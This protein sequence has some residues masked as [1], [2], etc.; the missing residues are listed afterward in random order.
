L[1]SLDNLLR[2]RKM[3]VILDRVFPMHCSRFGLS[4]LCATVAVFALGCAALTRPTA[5]WTS[6]VFTATS[7]VLTL[8]ILQA[9][10]SGG[11][12]RAFHL[13]FALCGWL[14]LFDS[15]VL[16]NTPL[17]PVL[18]TAI[19]LDRSVPYVIPDVF[20]RDQSGQINGVNLGS[21]Y[22]ITDYSIIGHCL[23][24]M[25]SA[26]AGGLVTVYFRERHLKSIEP[27]TAADSARKRN[28]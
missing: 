15:L 10:Y 24:A 11:A 18:L 2:F 13:G 23:W 16:S 12:M 6:F 28:G 25:L 14:Y 17:H 27:C 22:S 8:A 20:T 5:I 21:R 7:V 1:Q 3:A 19:V 9:P 26:L 4:S